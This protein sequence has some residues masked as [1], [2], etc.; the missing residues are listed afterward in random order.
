M[1]KFQKFQILM[2]AMLASAVLASACGGEKGETAPA[3]T[4]VSAQPETT[5]DTVAKQP[6]TAESPSAAETKDSSETTAEESSESSSDTN[7]DS[8]DNSHPGFNKISPEELQ[9]RL[10]NENSSDSSGLT[11]TLPVSAEEL[12][13]ALGS[14]DGGTVTI[15]SG[16]DGDVLEIGSFVSIP[17]GV[18]LVLDEGV[19]LSV[20]E[21]GTLNVEGSLEVQSDVTN[22]GSIILFEEGFLQVDGLFTN[23]GMLSNGDLDKDTPDGE[24][25]NCQIVAGGGITNTGSILN[26]GIIEGTITNDGGTI[27]LIGGTVKSIILNGGD[28]IEN[29]GKYGALSKN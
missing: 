7:T 12:S 2:T 3:D 1:K 15:G 26:T 27:T 9:Q 22:D 10:S 18:T 21:G 13:Q 19:S 20:V 29:G 23:T 8:D 24:T 6:E 4:T 14:A 16:A 17:E 11:L 5:Q 25:Q 28:L